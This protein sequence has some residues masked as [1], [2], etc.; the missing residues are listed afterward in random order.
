MINHLGDTLELI[1]SV[2]LVVLFFSDIIEN[3]S[4]ESESKAEQ[5]ERKSKLDC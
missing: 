5:K 4:N 2:D 1:N 3:L